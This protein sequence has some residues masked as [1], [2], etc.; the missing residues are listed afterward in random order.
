MSK[1]GEQPVREVLA[2]E[3]WTLTSAAQQIGVTRDHLRKASLGV[4]RPSWKVRDE[5]PKLVNRPLEE[6][7]T[8]EALTRPYARTGR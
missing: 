8:A 5:L 2:D 3:R 4:Y 7:F 1:Y 6:L